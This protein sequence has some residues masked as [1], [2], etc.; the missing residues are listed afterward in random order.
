MAV[1]LCHCDVI[2]SQ[3]NLIAWAIVQKPQASKISALA[4]NGCL[5]FL[6]YSN[7]QDGLAQLRQVQLT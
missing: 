5:F 2:V 4:Q 3:Q 6:N 1:F 7:S